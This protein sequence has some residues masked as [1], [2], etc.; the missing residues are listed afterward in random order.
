MRFDDL[1]SKARTIGYEDFELVLAFA[2]FL[3][4]HLFVGI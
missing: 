1:V 4:E 3:T 2:L